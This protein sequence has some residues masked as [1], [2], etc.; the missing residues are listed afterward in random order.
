[1]VER[2]DLEFRAI[3]RVNSDEYKWSSG[4]QPA[5]LGEHVRILGASALESR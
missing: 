3:S 5:D 2:W 4:E 1:M